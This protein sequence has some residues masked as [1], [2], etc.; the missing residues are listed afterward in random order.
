MLTE[1]FLA[2]AQIGDQF[3]LW[4]LVVLSIVSVALILERLFV[5]RS[6]A[7]HSQLVRAKVKAALALQNYDIVEEL[8][9]DIT[10][11][12]GRALSYGLKHLKESGANG[13]EEL[14]NSIQ[15]IE[16]PDLEKYLGF[17]ATLGSNAPY[18]GLLG[19]VMGIMKAFHD[20][21]VASEGGQQT[22]MAG[23]SAAL[24]ATAA[25]LFVAIPAVLAYNY[26]SKKTKTILQNLDLV[27]ELC[28]TMAK[29]KGL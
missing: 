21:S 2:V 8:S 16:K 18:I 22:V 6:A 27:K 28:L 1:R 13:L 11:I 23:I 9:K 20:L 5:L 4:L 17:M 3:I 26:F 29:K 15:L 10:T 7:N 25:G 14:F 24:V 12:E 19:T